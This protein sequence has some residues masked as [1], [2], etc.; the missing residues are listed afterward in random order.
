MRFR[1]LLLLLSTFLAVALAACGESG[2]TELEA[3]RASAVLVEGPDSAM[4]GDTLGLKA[5]V[6]DQDGNAMAGESV[7]W[8]SSNPAVAE[9][10]ASGE[11]HS[12]SDGNAT[13]TAAAGEVSGELELVIWA[14]PAPTAIDVEG[15][16]SLMVGDT[17][18]LQATVTDQYGEIMTG[19]S[20]EWTSSDSSVVAVTASGAVDVLAE[21]TATVTAAAGDA[22]GE[23]TV[24][25]HP[26]P[27]VELT[28]ETITVAALGDTVPVT[29][30]VSGTTVSVELSLLSETR[31]NSD[32]AVAAVAGEAIVA[33]GG[34]VA[35]YLATAETHPFSAPDTLLV[36][37]EP[38]T[39]YVLRIEASAPVGPDSPLL[40]HG[41]GLSALSA[42]AITTGGEAAGVTTIDSA[43]LSVTFDAVPQDVC[44]GAR[45][46]LEVAGAD[47]LPEE[48]TIQRQRTGA[49]SLMAG[50]TRRITQEEASCLKLEGPDS[51]TYALAYYDARYAYSKE[52]DLPYKKNE[53]FSI[54]L[55]DLSA[56]EASAGTVASAAA[57]PLSDFGMPDVHAS[58][59]FSLQEMSTAALA[60]TWSTQTTP[61]ELGDTLTEA[62][63]CESGVDVQVVGVVDGYFAV[64]IPVDSVAGLE[65]G[66]LDTYLAEVQEFSTRHVDW[67]QSVF[68]RPALPNG[69]YLI[70]VCPTTTNG[71]GAQLGYMVNRVSV[72]KYHASWSRYYVLA[73]EYAHSAEEAQHVENEERVGFR[74]TNEMWFNEGVADMIGWRATGEYLEQSFTA[75][76]QHSE[77]LDPIVSL[78]QAKFGAFEHGY[79]GSASFGFDL[80]WRVAEAR[81]L[82]WEEAHDS[83]TFAMA[84]NRYGCSTSGCDSFEGLFE[85]MQRHLSPTW[86]PVEGILTWVASHALDD[87]V[88]SDV[89]RYPSLYRAADYVAGG[90][91]AANSFG[92][93]LEIVAYSGDVLTNAP[94]PI[95]GV[96]S[97]AAGSAGWYRLVGGGGAF[98]AT[99]D[100]AHVEWLLIRFP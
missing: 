24:R 21:G 64:S 53:E 35:T 59:P 8:S 88:V 58:S 1:N 99:S 44:Y 36:R 68:A 19:A 57:A 51:A 76:L 39:P 77:A 84:H 11:V 71:G 89:Y 55:A 26:H 65:D 75:N 83:V 7:D 38:A 63:G 90:E 5:T 52:G 80:A 45:A 37:V 100:A 46:T 69:Q 10:T 66:F 27:P 97:L 40:L 12:L 72:S 22:H 62:P 33:V 78:S 82:G 23:L 47:M 48:A 31:W 16:D 34:G 43:T 13:I 79:T 60:G 81:G 73:H 2:T 15:P 87:L 30:T 56:G 49:I 70:A 14:S 96:A 3:P 29:A 67:I 4:V 9:V 25:V 20:V 17:A 50:E 18:T 94:Q 93:Q 41:Y 28:E 91:P 95:S 6:L 32:L 86:D 74:P 42:G 61:F 98:R 85:A 54:T 92:P